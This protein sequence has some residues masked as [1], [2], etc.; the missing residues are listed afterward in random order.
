VKG[1]DYLHTLTDRLAQLDFHAEIATENGEK[2]AL[3]PHATGIPDPGTLIFQLSENA[4]LLTGHAE[5][6]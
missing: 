6:I 2:I 5:L 4:T 3:A 1:V